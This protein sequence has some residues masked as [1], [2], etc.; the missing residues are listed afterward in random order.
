MYMSPT[1]GLRGRQ[2]RHRGTCARLLPLLT[3]TVAAAAPSSRRFSSPV[4]VTDRYCRCG[5]AVIAALALAG[6]AGEARAVFAEAWALSAQQ[7]ALPPQQQQ[8]AQQGKALNGSG[9]VGDRQLVD[10]ERRVEG[11]GVSQSPPLSE[12]DEGGG[13]GGGGSEGA[14]GGFLQARVYT[15][16]LRACD[17]PHQIL[18]IYQK[19]TRQL[20]SLDA[21]SAS[22]VA[23]AQV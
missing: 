13:E 19:M 15:A 7:H 10:G 21:E 1:N 22:L 16:A 17:S 23:A 18:E 2:R 4:T 11:G 12:R 9:V 14:A 6:R 20:L 5:S 8:H 3:V